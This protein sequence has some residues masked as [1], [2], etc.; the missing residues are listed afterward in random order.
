LGPIGPNDRTYEAAL[1]WQRTGQ[2]TWG[3][4]NNTNGVTPNTA[5][6][7]PPPVYTQQPGYN[8]PPPVYT[9]QQPQQPP[10]PVI[11]PN[12]EQQLIDTTQKI[13]GTIFR[14]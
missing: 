7:Q 9:Q 3:G 14:R 12:D 10:P 4:R 8:Q 1:E 6:Q 13:I 5:Q 2:I 11:S